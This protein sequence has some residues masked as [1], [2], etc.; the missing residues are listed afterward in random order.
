MSFYCPIVIIIVFW[1]VIIK[2]LT[3]AIIMMK[4][5]TVILIMIITIVRVMRLIRFHPGKSIV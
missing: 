3:V 2:S 4:I 5:V 1:G